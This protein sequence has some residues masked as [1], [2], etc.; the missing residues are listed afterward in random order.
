MVETNRNRNQIA[1]ALPVVLVSL[2]LFVAFGWSSYATITDRPG[3]NGEMYM[4]YQL[5]KFQYALYTVLVSFSGLLFMVIV[6]KML[7]NRQ[8]QKLKDIFIYFLILVVVFIACEIYLQ[9]RFTGK[10]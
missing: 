6:S 4:Y 1:W 7:V 9:T 8:S 3:A 10:A 5:T 2:F